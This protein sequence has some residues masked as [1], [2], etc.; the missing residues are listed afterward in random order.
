MAEAHQWES[1]PHAPLDIPAARTATQKHRFTAQLVQDAKAMPLAGTCAH[2]DVVDA[3]VHLYDVLIDTSERVLG[4]TFK[5]RVTHR[6]EIVLINTPV[7]IFRLSDH[8][9]EKPDDA[10][11]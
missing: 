8:E 2:Y 1:D 10:P 11:L 7:M 3:T 5:K 6:T 4:T 9:Q